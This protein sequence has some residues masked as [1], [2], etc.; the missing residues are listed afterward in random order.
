M[1]EIVTSTAARH[2]H[3]VPRFV[4]GEI[5]AFQPGAAPRVLS[6]LSNAW[7]A[8]PLR[9]PRPKSTTEH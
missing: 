7:P 2:A 6:L 4:S 8:R 3:I 9:P 5:S 1:R